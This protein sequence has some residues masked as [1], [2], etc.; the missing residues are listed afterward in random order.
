MGSGGQ[1]L[2]GQG[3]LSQDGP[4]LRAV[5]GALIAAS[6]FTAPVPRIAGFP[7]FYDFD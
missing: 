2:G 7:C 6:S 3:G 1:G 4:A 5:S